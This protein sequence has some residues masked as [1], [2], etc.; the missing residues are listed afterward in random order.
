M[1]TYRITAKWGPMELSEVMDITSDLST[2]NEM[3]YAKNHIMY[4]W[5]R[6]FGPDFINGADEIVV[7]SE[8]V[9]EVSN[10]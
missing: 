2:E 4:K 10:A 1:T 5:M 6:I 7:E 8:T 3:E 9:L